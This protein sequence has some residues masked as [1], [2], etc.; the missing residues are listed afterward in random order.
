MFSRLYL[1]GETPQAVPDREPA[2]RKRSYLSGWLILAMLTIGYIFWL[3]FRWVAQPA[4]F[5]TLPLLLIELLDLIEMATA[6]TLFLLWAGLVWR[7]FRRSAKQRSQ[8][9]NL[10]QLYELSPTD[11]ERYVATLFRQKGYRVVLRGKSGDHGVDLELFGEGH[12]RG[13]VQCKRYRDTVGEKIVRDLYGTLLHERASRAFLVTTA[14]I[15]TAARRW[16]KGK[17]ITLIDGQTLEE[18]G[19]ALAKKNSLGTNTGEQAADK[20]NRQGRN[21]VM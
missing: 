2:F 1:F 20:L 4:L 10:A 8:A 14:E 18:I 6:L 15:S 16:A 11:F 5:V 3:G 19:F 9:H 17:P 12:K 7:H 21:T 13:I